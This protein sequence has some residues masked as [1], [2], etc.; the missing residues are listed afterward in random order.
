MLGGELAA[1]R[2]VVTMLGKVK[3][4][5][6]DHWYSKATAKTKQLPEEKTYNLAVE[7]V[8]LSNTDLLYEGIENLCKYKII[9]M[10]YH[11]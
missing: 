11:T 10:L 3:L 8:D 6:D 2:F 5:N 4:H 1:A 7:A 9:T